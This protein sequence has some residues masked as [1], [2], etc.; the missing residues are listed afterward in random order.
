MTRKSKDKKAPNM[1][2]ICPE[3]GADFKNR[4][5]VNGHMQ[6]AHK[7]K[8]L[9]EL[10]ARVR[11]FEISK[12]GEKEVTESAGWNPEDMKVEQPLTV[13]L[14]EDYKNHPITDDV[15]VQKRNYDRLSGISNSPLQT[16][17]GWKTT[18]SKSMPFTGAELARAES[19]I[20][21]GFAKDLP[22]LMRKLLHYNFE[23]GEWGDENMAKEQDPID[24]MQKREMLDAYLQKMKSGASNP[25]GG[26]GDSMKEM[27][28]M[29]KQQMQLDMMKN[30]MSKKNDESSQGGGFNMN[31]MI[32]FMFLEKMMDKGQPQQS[33][34]EMKQMLQ[35]LLQQMQSSNKEK[36]FDMKIQELKNSMSQ[37][38]G[39]D[40]GMKE[41]MA[42]MN[43]KDKDSEKFR[44]MQEQ[45]QQQM[46]QKDREF[47]STMLNDKLQKLNDEI[48]SI[49]NDGSYSKEKLKD[50]KDQLEVIKELNKM[51][52]GNK[53]EDK[54]DKIGNAVGNTAQQL[55]P[56]LNQLAEGWSQKRADRMARQSQ[57]QQPQPQPEQQEFHISQEEWDRIQRERQKG[58]SEQAPQAGQQ[59][60]GVRQEEEQT[61]QSDPVFSNSESDKLSRE[62][63]DTIP[64]DSNLSQSEE[65]G[66]E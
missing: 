47:M 2:Y 8:A 48:N 60:M 36:E 21:A 42:I 55:S 66:Q 39:S 12:D 34:P 30:A 53:D 54:W 59:G 31:D 32:Q 44:Q 13:E 50:W 4:R 46:T 28:D 33:D 38:K 18:S 24:Q 1:K 49:K 17:Q 16:T 5:S 63:L 29:M 20:Q 6:F 11:V 25:Q 27:M 62:I 64:M 45:Y 41:L 3:C 26:G 56:A 43:Q 52:K 65:T 9:N 7:D 15:S 19:M 37:N 40:F 23:S 10:K 35:S 51:V 22:D 58:G 61:Q 14:P 57:A